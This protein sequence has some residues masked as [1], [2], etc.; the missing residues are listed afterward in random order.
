MKSLPFRFDSERHIYTANDTGERLPSITQ[1]IKAA[2]LI[3]D[4]WYTDSSA[5]RGTSVHQLTAAFD[6][7]ALTLEDVK[8][9]PLEGFLK[10]HV[11]LMGIMRPAWY[12]VEQAAAHATLRYAG[13]PDRVGEIYGARAV[14]EIKTGPPANWHQI[15]TALQAILVADEL[16]RPA[17]EV[18]RFTEY[19]TA[20]GTY[21]VEQHSNKRD[22]DEAYRIVRDFKRF[23]A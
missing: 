16:Q 15:Q 6:L 4:R 2:G 9:S 20:S 21:R 1:L 5:S 13:C 18:E 17:R 19:I 22:F 11:E 10:A 3:D 7:D 12:H 23:A 14:H 8:G